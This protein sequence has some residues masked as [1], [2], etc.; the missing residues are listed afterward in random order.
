MTSIQAVWRSRLPRAKGLSGAAATKIVGALMN[1]MA[2]AVAADEE[3]SLPGSGKFRLKDR[4]ARAGRNP[5]TGEAITIAACKKLT[6]T[7]A[8]AL[9]DRL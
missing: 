9:K 1:M 5:A 2:E 3:I 8:K 4:P 6:F 7:P